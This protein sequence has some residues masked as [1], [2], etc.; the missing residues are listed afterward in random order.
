MTFARSHYITGSARSGSFPFNLR[1]ELLIFFIGERLPPIKFELIGHAVSTEL[2]ERRGKRIAYLADFTLMRKYEFA[3]RRI[4]LVSRKLVDVER[5][6]F[7]V[8]DKTKIEFL[9]VAI[10]F[11]EVLFFV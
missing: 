1:L 7:S 8:S 10:P 3:L 2:I 11:E 4:T 9:R 5:Q 6:I